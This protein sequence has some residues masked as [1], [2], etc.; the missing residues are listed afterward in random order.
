MN[1]AEVKIFTCGNGIRQGFLN[2]S[3][4]ADNY[5]SFIYFSFEVFDLFI[6]SGGVMAMRPSYY[7][8]SIK[9]LND[10]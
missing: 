2:S 3:L 7:Y 1:L 9:Q 6:K 5:A 8:T 4:I 10:N